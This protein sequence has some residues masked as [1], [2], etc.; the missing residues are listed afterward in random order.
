MLPHRKSLSWIPSILGEF[1]GNDY[2]SRHVERPP[3][4][5]IDTEK[6]YM[7]E[8]AA[9]GVAKEEFEIDLV[10]D[11]QL[12]IK[13][14]NRH[15]SSKEPVEGQKYLR[16][17]FCCYEFEQTMI[18]P[19]NV[20]KESITARKDDGILKIEIPKKAKEIDLNNSKKIEIK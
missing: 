7:I 3:I 12:K 9:P 10:G 8:I 14:E 1:I 2:V 16:K 19:E 11:N 6:S 13:I 5:I 20:D 4:N 15:C 18:L 17:E